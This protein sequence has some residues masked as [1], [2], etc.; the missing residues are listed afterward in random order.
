MTESP[1][2]KIVHESLDTSR[3]E[4]AVQ[5]A[6]VIA[7]LEDVN[8]DQLMPVYNQI[9]HVLEHIFSNPPDPDAQIE[10]TFTYEQYRVTVG[11]DGEAKFVKAG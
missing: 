11:Q 3:D 7:S 4:P 1:D 10:V 9:D 6:E 5:V 2:D 8:S